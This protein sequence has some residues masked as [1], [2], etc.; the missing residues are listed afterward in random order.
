MSITPPNNVYSIGYQHY[1]VQVTC[2]AC[3]ISTSQLQ[4]LDCIKCVAPCNGYVRSYLVKQRHY[5][6][7]AMNTKLY[8]DNLNKLVALGLVDRINYMSGAQWSGKI[9]YGC[10][11]KKR[12]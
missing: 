7:R 12:Q 5:N 9:V 1:I 11:Y 2:R 8:Y 6:I 10:T 4:L 3:K